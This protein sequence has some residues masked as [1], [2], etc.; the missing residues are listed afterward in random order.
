VKH[1]A[2]AGCFLPHTQLWLTE[3]TKKYRIKA[4][5]VALNLNHRLDSA[6]SGRQK[7][8]KSGIFTKIKTAIINGGLFSAMMLFPFYANA[9]SV[10]PVGCFCSSFDTPVNNGVGPVGSCAQTSYVCDNG[11]KYTSCTTCNSGYRRVS[12][13]IGSHSDCVYYKCEAGCGAGNYYNN[14][15]YSCPAPGTSEDGSGGITSCYVP[16]NQ[17]TGS[18]STGNWTCTSAAYYQN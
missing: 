12:Y 14:G 17:L 3:I 11:L 6:K 16:A 9:I 15:C 7:M 2:F 13:E 5:R 4:I 18:D 8:Q 1:P 10:T